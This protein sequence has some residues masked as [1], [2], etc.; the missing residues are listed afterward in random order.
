MPAEKKIILVGDEGCGKTG[1]IF[2]Y[3][4]ENIPDPAVP[5][6]YKEYSTEVELDDG[7]KVP[8]VLW[9]TPSQDHYSGIRSMSYSD[10]EAVILCYSVADPESLVRA[11]EKWMQEIREHLPNVPVVLV[12]NKVDLRTDQ[13]LKIVSPEEGKAL[14][15]KIKAFS[16]VECSA[17]NAENV[18]EVFRAATSA[19]TAKTA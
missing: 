6:I 9:I 17:K 16:Y 5:T 14:A 4:T 7:T 13:N 15:D 12:G 8:I 3:F 19:A 18:R 1:L 2:S 10:A 11:E